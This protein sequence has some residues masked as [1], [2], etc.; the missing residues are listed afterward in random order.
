MSKCKMIYT[1]SINIVATILVM[2]SITGCAGSNKTNT[3]AGTYNG[4]ARNIGKGLAHAFITLDAEKKPAAIGIRLTESALTGLPAEHP[5]DAD[6]YEYVLPMPAEAS[7]SGYT[8]IV[9]DWNPE[10]HIPPGVYDKPHFD[11]HFY[12]IS[13]EQREKITAKGEDLAKA[14]KQPAP[15]FMPEGYILP[16]GT[17]V[18]RMGSHAIDPSS[19]E[20]NKLPF[21][22]TFIYG[23]YDGSMAFLEPMVSKTFLETKPDVTDDIKLPKAYSQHGYYPTQYSVKYN[24][25]QREYVITMEGLIYR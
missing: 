12:L 6:G 2:I 17:E 7:I 23:F 22:K 1:I 5:A 11:F 8:H 14:H 10:G 18:A 25:A 13:P 4:P 3:V 9:I 20:F 15:E 21:T 16:D 19:P 24:Q